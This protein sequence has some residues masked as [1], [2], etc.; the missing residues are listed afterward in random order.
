MSQSQI[1]R[2]NDESEPSP[3][4]SAATASSKEGDANL[5]E[6]MEDIDLILNE[7]ADIK[8]YVQKGGQ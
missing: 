8:Y 3:A 4:S 7:C 1:H 6:L 2:R 5:D